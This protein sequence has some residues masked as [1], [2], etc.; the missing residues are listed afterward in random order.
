MKNI[1]KLLIIIIILLIVLL[2]YN[3]NYIYS[4]LYENKK[5]NV[6]VIIHGYAPRSFKYTYE[7][8]EQNI[9]KTLRI[10]HN[11]NVY[12]YSLLSRDNKI[13]S[14]RSEE[15]DI[16][17]NNH[18]SK[19]LKCTKLETEYQ[20]D[21]NI[22]NNINCT[23]YKEKNM[24]LNFMRSLNSELEC[25]K[26]FPLYNYDVSVMVSSDSL[27][28]KKIN[29]QEIKD[30]YISN[31]LYTTDFNQWGGIANGFYIAP[32]NILYKICTRYNNFPDWCSKNKN[33]NAEKFL[34]YIILKNNIINKNR[35]I[36][37]FIIFKELA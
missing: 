24:N 20:E 31:C 15:N 5:Y 3:K 13:H 27:I 36:I 1:N 6:A 14:S 34:K 10:N 32:P 11:V 4:K 22:Y 23:D 29:E 33:K 2:F 26:R 17:I 37:K 21:I 35:A 19:L 25:T 18:D 7:S 30:C 16:Y 8:I 12:H 28:L 9:I